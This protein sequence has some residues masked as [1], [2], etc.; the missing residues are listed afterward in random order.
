MQNV[1]DMLD[2]LTSE[3]KQII[4]EHSLEVFPIESCG[5]IVDTNSGQKVL[6]SKN[7]FNSEKKFLIDNS[8]FDEVKENEKTIGVYHSHTRDG[9]EDFSPEDL[10]VSEKIK[11][12]FVLYN[13]ILDEF[14]G[15]I[16]T[17][18]KLSLIGRPYFPPV[19][20]CITIL[21]E[22][23]E[24][25]LGINID[26]IEESESISL[27]NKLVQTP[28]L[29][30]FNSFKNLKDLNKSIKGQPFLESFLNDF[31]QVETPKKHDVFLMKL[32]NFMPEFYAHCGVFNT[33]ETF[34]AVRN[35][36]STCESID[37]ILDE[38]TICTIYLRHKSLL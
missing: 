12:P 37:K 14:K 34:I 15:Y 28:S 20:T 38:N 5:I 36:F 13:V 9:S 25:T 7:I 16:P 32:K 33:D 8:I 30:L 4:K 10:T 2:K 17:S 27:F 29:T 23:Y 3:S 26:F 1:T 19:F 11:I 31:K 18:K 22:Y 6:K 21:R 24:E 35:G